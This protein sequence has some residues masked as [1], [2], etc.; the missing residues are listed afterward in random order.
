[1][2]EALMAMWGDYTLRVVLAGAVLIGVT[3]GTLGVYAFLRRQSLLGDAVSHCTLPGIAFAF[4]MTGT[5]EPLVLLAGAGVTGWIGAEVVGRVSTRTRISYDAALAMVLSVFFGVGLVLL[6][7]IQKMPTAAQAGLDTFLFGQA[8]TLLIEDVVTM[9]VLGGGALLAMVLFWKEWKLMVFDAEYAAGL[10][11]SVRLLDALLIGTLIV[12]VVIG[13]QAVGVVLMSAMLVA[14]AAAARQWTNRFGPMLAIAAAVGGVS[15]MFGTAI[16]SAYQGMPTGP[17]IV[18]VVGS[19]VVVS[20][21]FGSAR[22]LIWQWWARWMRWRHILSDRL[23]VAAYEVVSRH[24]D[25]HRPFDADVLRTDQLTRREL[26]FL[27]RELERKGWMRRDGRWWVM[28]AA[29]MEA[30][31]V[32][33][34]QLPGS[35]Q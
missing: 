18:L 6:T 11:W 17:A 32:R 33:Q 21:L 34:N 15:G 4:W 20:L 29:G 5:K 8:A 1:M 25:P 3:S 22:G 30:A 31:Q 10:G 19:L 27:L 14:P 7:W 23:L 28:T 12:A 9:T 13:L 26:G 35:L 16:S 2:L 24:E